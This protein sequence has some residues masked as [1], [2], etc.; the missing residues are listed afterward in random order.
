VDE[1]WLRCRTEFL[2]RTIAP[3]SGI[4]GAPNLGGAPN[5]GMNFGFAF[6]GGKETESGLNKR[7]QGRGGTLPFPPKP[8]LDPF[9]ERGVT[10]LIAVSGYYV[11]VSMTLNVDRTPVPGDGKPPL[12]PL[13][14]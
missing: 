7:A 14:R 3:Y 1:A 10:D 5:G 9:G 2:A 4:I 13:P 8:T 11:L 12:R 6:F